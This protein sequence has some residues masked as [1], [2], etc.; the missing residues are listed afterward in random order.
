[1]VSLICTYAIVLMFVWQ[2][3]RDAFD[4]EGLMGFEPKSLFKG[5]SGGLVA[6]GATGMIHRSAG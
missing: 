1:M 5:R 6:S 4:K 2:F 3:R